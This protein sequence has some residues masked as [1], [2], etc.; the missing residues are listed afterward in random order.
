MAKKHCPNCG[1]ALEIHPSDAIITCG[2]CGTSFTPEGSQFKEHF[3]LAVNYTESDAFDTL[4]AYLV[5]VPGVSDELAQIINLKDLSMTFYPYWV[6]NVHGNVSYRGV[7]R[8][9]SFRGQSGGRYNSINWEWVA[10]SGHQDQTH[11]I[12]LY[13]GPQ[14]RGELQ[15]YPIATRA[16]QYFNLEQAKEHTANILFSKVSEEAA[17]QQ[18]ITTT[19]NI[20]Y[21]RINRETAKVE[22][23]RETFEVTDHAYIHVPI[24]HIR[25]TVGGRGKVYEAGLDASNGRVLYAEVPRTTGFKLVTWARAAFMFLLGIVGIYLVYLTY[26]TGGSLFYAGLG[27]AI[28][29]LILGILI[30]FLAFRKTAAEAAR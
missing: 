12:R 8:K 27:L 1:G 22:D 18:A 3:A 20:I 21:S 4:K 11:Q 24:Y 28:I 6:Y 10:E 23:A 13:A 30:V 16:R 15:N 29:P 25:Y 19:R 14:T 5:K 17:R 2:Y 26:Q 7:D 9:A